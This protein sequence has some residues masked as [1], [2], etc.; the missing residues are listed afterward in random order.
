MNNSHLAYLAPPAETIVY[1]TLKYVIS[2]NAKGQPSIKAWRGKAKKPFANFYF[3]SVAD[4]DNWLAKTKADEDDRQNRA[5]TRKAEDDQRKA[6]AKEK[7]QV[8]TLLHN[9]WGY[10]Q[11]NCDF[12]QVTARTGCRVELTPIAGEMV[13]GSEGF[14]SCRMKPVRDKFCGK[15]ITKIIG[16]HGISFEYGS[17]SICKDTDAFCC[18]WYA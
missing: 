16:R 3:R 11:T 13:E 17:G 2:D 8:G 15:P 7:L 1:K 6:E 9:S 14:M 4:R 12:Y 10:D 5:V 18:S